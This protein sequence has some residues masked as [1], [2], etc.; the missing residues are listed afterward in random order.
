MIIFVFLNWCP[1]WSVWV[2]FIGLVIGGFFIS[3]VLKYIYYNPLRNLKP[4]LFKGRVLTNDQTQCLL[5]VLEKNIKWTGQCFNE[6]IQLELESEQRFTTVQKRSH[7]DDSMGS[8]SRGLSK[9][10]EENIDNE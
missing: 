8:D 9:M 2:I 1:P 10:E 4:L 6:T 3:Q 5:N 7:Q